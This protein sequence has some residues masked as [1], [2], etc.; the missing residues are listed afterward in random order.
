MKLKQ[1]PVASLGPHQAEF[2]RNI[3]LFLLPAMVVWLWI[4]SAL[5]ISTFLIFFGPDLAF[6]RNL[7]G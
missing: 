2:P 1:K 4:V 5:F 3:K 7:P 6:T